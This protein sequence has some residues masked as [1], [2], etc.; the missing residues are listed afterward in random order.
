VD[1]VSTRDEDGLA[2]RPQYS[3]TGVHVH[4]GC[5][6]PRLQAQPSLYHPGIHPGEMTCAA[7]GCVTADRRRA[8]GGR[9]LAEQG[10]CVVVFAAGHGIDEVRGTAPGA[11]DVGVAD[12]Y[13][14]TTRQPNVTVGQHVIAGQPL[15]Q[16]GSSGHSSGPHLH[17][18]VHLNGD[19]SFLAGVSRL[20]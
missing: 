7:G 17:F 8:V 3:V 10:Y 9:L 13:T 14:A 2:Q 11:G 16:V 20:R 4:D 1:N 6:C 19:A 12:P 15:R 18:E 5:A